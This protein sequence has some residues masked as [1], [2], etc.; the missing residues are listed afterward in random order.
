MIG[1]HGAS[2]RLSLMAADLAGALLLFGWLAAMAAGRHLLALPDA[3]MGALLAL[4]YGSAWVVALWSRGLYRLPAR[5][6]PLAEAR[7]IAVV[8]G[9]LAVATF[10]L[11]FLLG[12]TDVSRFFLISLYAGQ[13]MVAVGSRW[14]VRRAH[15]HLR[16]RSGGGSYMLVIGTGQA[17]QRFADQVE[18]HAALGLRVIGH[19][20]VPGDVPGDV[21]RPVLGSIGDLEG[22]LHDRVVDEVALCIGE[23]SAELAGAVAELCREEG[24][25]VRIPLEDAVRQ[26]GPHLVEDLDGQRV[27]SI[28]PGPDRSVALFAKRSLDIVL[29]GTLLLVVAPLLGL[30]ALRIRVTDGGPVIFRQRRVG[31]H[32]RTFTL[33]K[34]RTMGPDAEGRRDELV[35]RNEV[36]GRAFKLT[37]DPRLTRSGAFLRRTSLDELPQLWNVLRGEMS[38]VGPRPPLPEEVAGY[39]LWHRRRLSMKPGMTGLWQVRGRSDPVFDRWVRLDLD[40]IDRWTIRLDL[41]ILLRTIPAVLTLQGR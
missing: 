41:L 36:A 35:D 21:D 2:L 18:A 31:L 9:L 28:L 8:A 27:L 34:L 23:G 12:R 16:A 38:L 1:R 3:P 37:D 29:A 19:L 39:D 25:P 6:D 17:A 13:V 24:R 26:P 33:L 10:A 30:I 7:D 5:W 4:A 32:G 11:L 40:Y 22:V 15:R 20:S 14:I